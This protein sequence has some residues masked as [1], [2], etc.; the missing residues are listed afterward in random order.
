MSIASKKVAVLVDNY[1]E[2]AEFEEP[3]Q[4]L[5]AAGA[6]VTVVA[7]ESKNLQGMEHAKQADVFTADLLLADTN[8]EAYDALVLPGGVVNADKLRMH[9]QA[10]DWV[11]RFT[12]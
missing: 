12:D 4:K 5:K 10:R 11:N 9:M 1:F 2:Q 6:E 7:T 3:M 8:A